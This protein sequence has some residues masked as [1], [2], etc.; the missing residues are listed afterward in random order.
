MRNE[1]WIFYSAV[2]LHCISLCLF[3]LK[4]QLF[5]KLFSSSPLLPCWA[6]LKMSDMKVSEGHDGKADLAYGECP[7]KIKKKEKKLCL[8]NYSFRVLLI[9]S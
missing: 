7:S 8:I 3:I 2:N 4:R 6:Q 9:I 5:H 1:K